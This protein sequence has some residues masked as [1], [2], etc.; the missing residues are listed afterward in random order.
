MNIIVIALATII[1]VVAYK[2][3]RLTKG[4]EVKNEINKRTAD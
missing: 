1:V 2:F 4:W 3:G